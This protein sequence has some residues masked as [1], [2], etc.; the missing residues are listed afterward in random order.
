VNPLIPAFSNSDYIHIVPQLRKKSAIEFFCRG[1]AKGLENCTEV[2]DGSIVYKKMI[3][4][5]A[6]DYRCMISL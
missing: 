3:K 5:V 1:K 4:K 2:I 6:G